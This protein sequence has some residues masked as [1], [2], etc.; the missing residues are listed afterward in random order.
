M[1]LLVFWWVNAGGLLPA[2]DVRP[3]DS[4]IAG[5]AVSG[6]SLA[7]SP[8]RIV[9]ASLLHIDVHHLMV[10]CI[11]LGVFASALSILTR[12]R[13]SAATFFLSGW[14]GSLI[15]VCTQPGWFLGASAGVFGLLGG[16]AIQIG[17]Q[18]PSGRSKT[19]YTG[20]LGGILVLVA[21]GNIIA[22]TAGFLMGLT[23]NLV[24]DKGRF[25]LEWTTITVLLLGVSAFT[26]A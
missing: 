10:N 11:L 24:P 6:H 13:W 14:I 20:V 18:T 19:A 16:T 2:G 17:R 26:L 7:E 23:L 25:W 15:A 22:H 8:W 5:G 21:P 12:A 3:L 1:G 4:A 9:T